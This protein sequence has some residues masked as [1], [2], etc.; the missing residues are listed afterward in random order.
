MKKHIK[1]LVL[2]FDVSFSKE[3]DYEVVIRIGVHARNRLEVLDE[4]EPLMEV[5]NK[6]PNDM[7]V[8]RVG[9]LL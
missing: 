5:V 4:I 2:M 9:E 3:F 8:K 1:E 7:V 6:Y